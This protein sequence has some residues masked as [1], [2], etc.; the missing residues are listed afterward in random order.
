MLLDERSRK[1]IGICRE[2][3]MEEE[4]RDGHSA[5]NGRGRERRLDLLD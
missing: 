2:T 3:N 4:K 5:S 1:D